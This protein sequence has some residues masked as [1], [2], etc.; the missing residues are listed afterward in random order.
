VGLCHLTADAVT[1]L[2]EAL[3]VAMGQSADERGAVW[4]EWLTSHPQNLA[5]ARTFLGLPAD[6]TEE[7]PAP[8]MVATCCS[9]G[10]G[11]EMPMNGPRPGCTH[12]G[13]TRPSGGV[14]VAGY[15]V[16]PADPGTCYTD[17]HI[18]HDVPRWE[19]GNYVP[20]CGECVAAHLGVSVED[21]P[22]FE[23]PQP[24]PTCGAAPGE[25][26]KDPLLTLVADATQAPR[27]TIEKPQERPDRY[28]VTEEYKADR[29]AVW[30]ARVGRTVAVRV[31]CPQERG[32][33]DTDVLRRALAE[34]A[35]V[36][37]D[38]I[39]PVRARSEITVAPHTWEVDRPEADTLPV[40]EEPAP[41][42]MAG[43]PSGFSQAAEAIAAEYNAEAA[44]LLGDG[45]RFMRHWRAE[46]DSASVPVDRAEALA[47]VV[48]ALRD[49]WTIGRHDGGLGLVTPGT[50]TYLLVP[51]GEEPQEQHDRAE[52]IRQEVTADAERKPC[53]GCGAEAGEP[54]EPLS[55]CEVS[56]EEAVSERLAAEEG[57]S[58]PLELTREPWRGGQI[59]GHQ[60][61]YGMGAFSERYCG[62]RKAPGLIE[63]REHYDETLAN[64]GA[65]AARRAIVAGVAV[66]DPSAPLV[67]LWEPQEGTEPVE[68]TEEERAMF[69]A[70][71]AD[72][73][74]VERQAA[75][76]LG[77][78]EQWMM[79]FC[80]F[81]H[82]PRIGRVDRAT[83]VE[84][85]VWA[86][87]HGGWQVYRADEGGVN[88]ESP[89]GESSYRLYRPAPKGERV[90]VNTLA[91]GDE[92]VTRC[93]W[94]V[95]AADGWTF[96]AVSN[97]GQKVTQTV[98]EGT[99]VLRTRRAADSAQEDE[100]ATPVDEMGTDELLTVLRE[101][102]ASLPAGSLFARAW[103]ALDQTLTNG[104]IE[105]LPAP[106][107]GYG[108]THVPE[109]ADADTRASL[110]ARFMPQD[111]HDE[112]T[113][114]CVE[115]G[116]VQVYTYRADGRLVVSVD[117]DGVDAEGPEIREDG[118]VP[119]VISVQGREVFEG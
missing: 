75:E 97:E 105:C 72:P 38:N 50:A 8:R 26:C 22:G 102:A 84:L 6:S 78:G 62:K 52:E 46:E 3:T 45:E 15:V 42:S 68:P 40:A 82:G 4:H 80:K 61:Q 93:G 21:L 81:G 39:R 110:T 109:D 17:R 106:W 34:H 25:P 86:L 73:A 19:S 115:V 113:R 13:E 43:L 69:A 23:T 70:V 100:E 53:P 64:H 56:R 83:A 48:K 54:C 9:C 91:P 87:R 74:D 88:L 114:P 63:C 58:A 27:P 67:L 31:E 16:R 77:E 14:V 89:T 103:A 33:W 76:L 2:R 30:T 7:T 24:C 79:R 101:E 5:T 29:T 18:V 44:A 112:D 90:D 59:C 104:G 20:R 10:A 60:T 71:L 108:E 11:I 12:N 119:M 37:V 28:T 85:I 57:D 47:L 116:T 55:T 51:I 107:D 32:M 66:G 96:T 94:T 117:L 98:P 92:F 95:L 35:G 41:R 99:Q 36:D 65:G 49:E 118:T 1:Y 111:P